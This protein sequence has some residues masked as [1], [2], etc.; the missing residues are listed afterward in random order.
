VVLTPEAA[1]A[2]G[3]ARTTASAPLTVVMPP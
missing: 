3:A 2:L 1:D